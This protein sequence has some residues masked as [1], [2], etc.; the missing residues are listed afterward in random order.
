M[1]STLAHREIRPS[2]SDLIRRMRGLPQASRRDDLRTLTQP[3]EN[4]DLLGKGEISLL[5][6][7]LGLSDQRSLRNFRLNSFHF[8]S[9]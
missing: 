3:F 1:R 6:S 5:L 2:P 7:P 9:R 8:A 4:N